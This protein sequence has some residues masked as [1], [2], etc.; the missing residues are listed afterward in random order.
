MSKVID[1]LPRFVEEH[2]ARHPDAFLPEFDSDDGRELYGAWRAV[3]VKRGVQD[4]A[5]ATEASQLLVGESLK[6]PR[7][8]FPTLVALAVAVY[9]QR[10]EA[11]TPGVGDPDGREAAER[12]SKSCPCGATGLVTAWHPAPARGDPAAVAAYCELCPMGRW[13][14]K[15]H[16]DKAPD[17]RR[18]LDWLPGML[19]R[20]WLPGPPGV[21]PD[22]GYE[23]FTPGELIRD[24]TDRARAE[25]RREYRRPQPP[26]PSR[27]AAGPDRILDGPPPAPAPPPQPPPVSRPDTLDG[28]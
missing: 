17:V 18:R 16:R 23:H 7:D 3:L 1:W 27:L 20:G 15:A 6:S 9:R 12:A 2:R 22:E 13:V 14:E 21:D 11:A 4:L 24:W 5:A 19:R 28:F 8:H 26:P 25:P 10:Q